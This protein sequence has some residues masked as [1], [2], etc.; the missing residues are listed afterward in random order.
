MTYKQSQIVQNIHQNITHVSFGELV[1]TISIL[2]GDLKVNETKKSK[3]KKDFF[4]SDSSEVID[5]F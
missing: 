4:L 2:E 1:S 5:V 3:S